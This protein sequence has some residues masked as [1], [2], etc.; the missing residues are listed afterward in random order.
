[1]KNN[2]EEEQQQLIDESDSEESNSEEKLSDTEREDDQN[3]LTAAH[4]ATFVIKESRDQLIVQ[5]N[6]WVVM[7]TQDGY[8]VDK[9]AMELKANNL[10]PPLEDLTLARAKVLLNPKHKNKHLLILTVKEIKRTILDQ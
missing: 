6:H 10:L 4:S 2:N 9:G 8:P 7:T 1:M 3:E 5:D